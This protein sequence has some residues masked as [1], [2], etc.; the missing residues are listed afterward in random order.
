MKIALDYISSIDGQSEFDK[1]PNSGWMYF[2][3]GRNP[4][5]GGAGSVKVKKMEIVLVGLILMI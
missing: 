3:N 1:G 4:N 5:M 2:V